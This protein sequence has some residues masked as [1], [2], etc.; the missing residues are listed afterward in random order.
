[1][2]IYC[3]SNQGHME[4]LDCEKYEKYAKNSLDPL[5]HGSC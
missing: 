1:M 3:K 2:P 5:R 4:S